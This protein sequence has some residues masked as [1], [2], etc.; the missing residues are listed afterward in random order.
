MF[1]NLVRQIVVSSAPVML[2]SDLRQRFSQDLGT[3]ARSLG[4]WANNPAALYDEFYAHLVGVALPVGVGHLAACKAPRVPD[5]AYRD[6]RT[7]F[8]G[9]PAVTAVLAAAA[10]LERQP[11]TLAERYFPELALAWRAT[12]Q[13]GAVAA[14][15]R[16][17]ARL[18]PPGRR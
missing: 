3:S 16:L 8:I 2:E 1:P 15:R 18:R 4:P 5:K 14:A 12:E 7:R 17:R 10:R 13:L 11:A 6:R 9:A